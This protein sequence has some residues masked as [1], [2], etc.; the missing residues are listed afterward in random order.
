MADPKE[1][2]VTKNAKGR[3]LVSRPYVP[4][5]MKPRSSWVGIPGARHIP[6]ADDPVFPHFTTIVADWTQAGVEMTD[7][8]MAVAVQLAATQVARAKER[9]AA[10]ARQGERYAALADAAPPPGTYGD[11]PDGVVYYIRRGRYVKIGT[12]TQL[13]NRMRDLLPDEVLAVEPG[14]YKLEGELHQRFA[15]LRLHPSCEYFLLDNELQAHID[16]VLERVGPPPSGLSQFKDFGPQV[17]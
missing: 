13:R 15:G 10:E 4:K 14:S 3:N 1:I 9:A 17:A 16:Q 11:A 12:T 5:S 6:A 8:L 7:E 2:D